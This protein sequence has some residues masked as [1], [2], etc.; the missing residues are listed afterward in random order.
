MVTPLHISYIIS[1]PSLIVCDNSAGSESAL[2]LLHKTSTRTS[3]Q[4]TSQVATGDHAEI[5]SFNPSIETRLDSISNQDSESP[6]LNNGFTEHPC[7]EEELEYESMAQNS[8]GQGRAAIPLVLNKKQ[9]KRHPS[10]D[11]SFKDLVDFKK[12]NGHTKVPTQFRPLG[13]WVSNQRRQYRFI[14]EGK[15][16]LLTMDKYKQ[17]ERIGFA[18]RCRPHPPWDQRFQELVDFK[19]I[20]GHMNVRQRSGPLGGWLNMQRLQY[21]LSKGNPHI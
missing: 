4:I 21:R 18:F 1:T 5:P 2:H 13:I 8:T 9:K 12:I 16:S 15:D 20:N 14:T 7:C 11:E 3:N 6:P 17:L 10:W 19:K